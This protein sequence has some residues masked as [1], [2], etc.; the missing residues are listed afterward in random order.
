MS[1]LVLWEFSKK[2][3]Y[4]FRSNRLIECV[5]ASMIIKN[6]SEELLAYKLQEDKFIIKGGGN[7]LYL[8][9]N[10]NESKEFIK[11]FSLNVLKEYPGLDLFMVSV[12]FNADTDDI[13]EK[14]KDIYIK[15]EVKKNRRMNAGNQIGFGI[16]RLCESTGYPAASYY[17]DEEKKY[18]SNEIKS[19]RDI[20][21]GNKKNYFKDLIPEGYE[22]SN[23]I[24][25]LVKNGSKSYVAVV[26]IDGNEMGK[27]IRSIDENVTKNNGESIKEFNY[28][29]LSVLKEFSLMINEKYENAFRDMC[30]IVGNNFNILKDYT[31]MN[32][33]LFPLRPLILAG[34]DITYISNGYIGVES[35]KIFI[36][37]LN[38]TRIIISGIDL[39]VL[40]ACAGI[41]IIK[42]GYP[43]IKGYSLAEDLCQNCKNVLLNRKYENT[44]AIDFHIAQGDMNRSI[45]EI[46]EEDYN[47][48]NNG[49]HLT[50]KPLILDENIDWRNYK[51]FTDILENINE[52]I[53]EGRVGRNKIKALK[54]VLRKGPEE[55]EYFFKFY[56]I[57]PDYFYGDYCFNLKDNTCM[58]EDSIESL[59]YFVKLSY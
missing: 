57:N 5:G 33:G 25:D 39:G 1:N 43:F 6:L 28:R 31:N 55:T 36:E 56:K 15:L 35:A 3:D 21:E 47:I 19:K 10:D 20:A 52:M 24:N 23:N 59:D 8:F 46:R 11:N 49:F 44:S 48:K 29:Y 17:Y 34:D 16:E 2:Q 22:L 9:D 53:N 12:P 30:S 14:I 51:S 37:N 50:M 54:E 27:K 4:I 58:Y 32:Q 13:K 18:I 45:F 40:H 41:A 42:K 7:T 38:K 26:H